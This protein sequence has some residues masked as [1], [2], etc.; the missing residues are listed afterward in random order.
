[1]LSAL[2]S[3]LTSLFNT[4]TNAHAISDPS[5][6]TTG[7]GTVTDLSTCL[8]GIGLMAFTIC[9][10]ECCAKTTSRKRD[11]KLA[12][13]EQSSVNDTKKRI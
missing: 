9:F 2:L 12:N 10:N 3:N 11:N 7:T 8:L 1:M 4:P 6:E 13:E 5:S